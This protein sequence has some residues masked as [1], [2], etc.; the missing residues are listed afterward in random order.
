VNCN[1]G[2]GAGTGPQH[3]ASSCEA[4]CRRDRQR[5]RRHSVQP[6]CGPAATDLEMTSSISKQPQQY[7]RCTSIPAG[8]VTP[9][10]TISSLFRNISNTNGGTQ[11]VRFLT[12]CKTVPCL[13]C[14]T[15]A[16]HAKCLHTGTQGEQQ[17]GKGCSCGSGAVAGSG[18]KAEG[19]LV[20]T[21]Q[22]GHGQMRQLTGAG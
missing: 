3:P 22:G 8:I 4:A 21:P 6:R 18:S 20:Q 13:M 17:T 9:N 19:L 14:Y 16:Y 5:S 7:D 10:H 1:D 2:S 11:Q 12:A 15:T